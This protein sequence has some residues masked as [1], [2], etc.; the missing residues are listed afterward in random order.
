MASRQESIVCD[1]VVGYITNPSNSLA[2][3]PSPSPRADAG[4]QQPLIQAGR[5]SQHC[6]AN[7][8]PA[9]AAS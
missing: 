1:N 8:E 6:Y 9:W 7:T 5:G 4:T 2:T 3:H